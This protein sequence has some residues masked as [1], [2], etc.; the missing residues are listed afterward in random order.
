LSIERLGEM[1]IKN[2]PENLKVVEYTGPNDDGKV[3]KLPDSASY[4]KRLET[5]VP[6][7]SVE[8]YRSVPGF[9]DP[10]S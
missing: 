8:K 4:R 2:L 1:A 10:N 9:T 3:T 5:Y 7:Y 6:R